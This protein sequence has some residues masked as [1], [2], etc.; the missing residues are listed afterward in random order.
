MNTISEK[1]HDISMY[2]EDFK[3]ALPFP[4]IVFDDFLNN[5]IYKNISQNLNK[6]GAGEKFDSQVEKNKWISRNSKLPDSLKRV[7]SAVN[8]LKMNLRML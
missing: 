1:Y 7:I 8:L 4:H 5:D 6:M 3:K 2:S